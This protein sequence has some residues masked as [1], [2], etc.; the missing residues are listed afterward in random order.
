MCALIHSIVILLPPGKAKMTLRFPLNKSSLDTSFHLNGLDPPIFSSLTLHLKITLGTIS[1]S[2]AIMLRE[3]ARN[4]LVPERRKALTV[5]W[6]ARNISKK[7]ARR[8]NMVVEGCFISDVTV[9]VPYSR[10]LVPT[11]S[12]TGR[13]VV[14]TRWRSQGGPMGVMKFNL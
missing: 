10:T 5:V 14:V 13:Q 8:L 6:T 12:L 3:E 11:R 9:L 2:L 4:A 1:P 7:T